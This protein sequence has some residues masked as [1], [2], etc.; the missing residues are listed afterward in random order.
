MLSS[1]F[2]R[3][4]LV[5]SPEIKLL[6]VGFEELEAPLGSSIVG[7]A[8]LPLPPL[9]SGVTHPFNLRNCLHAGPQ[10]YLARLIEQA[11]VHTAYQDS[12]IRILISRRHTYCRTRPCT[13]SKMG[14]FQY[15]TAHKRGQD[16]AR[17]PHFRYTLDLTPHP[18]EYRIK[19]PPLSRYR[20]VLPAT[21]TELHP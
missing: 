8:S 10:E 17:L 18:G 1:G 20:A 11:S 9:Q 13:A 4:S 3:L 19:Y 14:Q 5:E 12:I 6:T 7:I 15:L 21:P 2:L 16:P